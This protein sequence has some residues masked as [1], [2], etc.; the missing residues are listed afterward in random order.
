MT[1][2]N[3]KKN[4]KILELELRNKIFVLV[5]KYAGSH[6][7]EL[8]RK[9]SISYSTLKYH[10][11]FLVKH[12][13]IIEKIGNGNIKYYP[14]T[15]RPDDMEI[16]GLLR[17]KN[18]RKILLFLLTYDKCTH[19][20]LEGFTRLAPSTVNW[21]LDGLI[22]R[23]VV[24]KSSLGNKA[25]YKLNYNKEE[26]MKILIIYRESFVDSLIDKTIEMW[27]LR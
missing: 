10:L 23:G 15:I 25:L 17:Q 22:K 7:R 18:V 4:E 9:S 26:I 14:K 6:L 3:L 1:F 13:L 8:E 11:H 2:K 24:I 5:S 20:D 16:L 27:E 19:K 21:Y 12:N